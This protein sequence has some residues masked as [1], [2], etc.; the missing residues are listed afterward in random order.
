MN[1]L[2]LGG[3]RF[4]GRHLVETLARRGHRVVAFHRGRTLCA[5]PS[6]IEERFGDLNEDLSAADTEHWDAIVDVNAF[7]PE[8]VTRS[9][10]LSADR[11][12]LISTVSVYADFSVRG[13]TEDAPTIE[14]FDPQDAAAAYG[15]KKAACERLVRAGYTERAVILRPGLIAGRWDYTGRFSYWCERLLRGGSILVP[16]PPDRHVQFV[17]ASDLARFAERLLMGG[18]YGVFNVV[19][20]AR[21][22][23]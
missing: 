16:A 18:V 19:G 21:P 11:Y 23:S 14:A 5:F 6:A 3:T 15:G 12:L 8:Q 9:L 7:E 2:V 1:V 13:I 10:R 22:T 17:D 20:P 4:V